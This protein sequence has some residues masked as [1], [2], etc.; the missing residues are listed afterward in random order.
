MGTK[1][2]TLRAVS[3]VACSALISAAALA[4][5]TAAA[6]KPARNAPNTYGTTVESY[7]R[8]AAAEFTP[9]KSLFSYADRFYDEGP[10]SLRRYATYVC[11]ECGFVASPHL[12]SGALLTYVELDSC[13][14]NSVDVFLELYDCDY[15]GYC[16]SGPVMTLSSDNNVTPNACSYVAADVSA[17]GLTV[18]NY[19]RQLSVHV[20]NV[21]GDGSNSFSGVILG[22]KLQVAPAPATPTFNDVP[23]SDIGF[24]YIEALAA[25][26]ITGGCGGGAFCPTAPVTRR[27]MAIFLAKALGLYL[28]QY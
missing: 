23:T 11:S 28:P 7:Y 13:D 27:Q 20:N 22:Y 26:G 18:N 9:L 8:M 2:N 16:G 10:T 12:P 3:F 25:S 5:A 4:Q 15:S 24:Q 1:G 21:G 19:G 17:L 14:F 6:P